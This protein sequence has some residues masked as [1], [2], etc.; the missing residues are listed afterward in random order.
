MV[1]FDEESLAAITPEQFRAM[2]DAIKR[3]ARFLAFPYC[4]SLIVVTMQRRSRIYFVEPKESLLPQSIYFSM[5][6]L[7]FGWWGIP[8][9]P[10][11]T[12]DAIA[13]CLRGGRNVTNEVMVSLRRLHAAIATDQSATTFLSGLNVP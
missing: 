4:V 8:W 6:S 3:G 9:G 13:A 2:Q 10:I 12:I 7:V 5:V 1:I 11:Y